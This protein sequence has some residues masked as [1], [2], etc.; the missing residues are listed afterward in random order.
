MRRRP[1]AADVSD[2]VFREGQHGMEEQLLT[3]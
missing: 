1:M 2:E 3:P